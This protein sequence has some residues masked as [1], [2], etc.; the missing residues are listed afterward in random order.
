MEYTFP[1]LGFPR[2]AIFL[3]YASTSARHSFEFCATAPCEDRKIKAAKNNTLFI[4][5]F[6]WLV[7]LLFLDSFATAFGFYN[8]AHQLS[9]RVVFVDGCKM[10]IIHL[11]DHSQVIGI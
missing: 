1:S 4:S 8:G 3:L 10:L 11:C 7:H 9:F 2:S 5:Q 6:F